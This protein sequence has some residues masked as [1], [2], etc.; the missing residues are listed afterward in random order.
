[1]SGQDYAGI[2]DPDTDFDSWYTRGTGAAIARR[3]S[4]GERVLELGCATGLMT[5]SFVAAGATVVGVDRSEQYL[6][7]ARARGL[8]GAT[9]VQGE[10]E[11][12]DEGAPFAHVTA[13]NL[14]HEVPD[15]D[16]F[17]RRCRERLE[18]GGYLHL[19]LQNPQSIHRLA[20]LELGMIGALHEVSARGQKYATL[21]LYDADQ[22]AAMGEAAGMTPVDQEGVMLKPLPND[23]M[24]LL[25]EQVLDGFQAVARHFPRH[26]AM[27]YLVFRR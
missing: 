9:F 1:M 17:L 26:C 12:Y 24:A 13:T 25:P 10:A 7:R 27:N 15:P 14:F 20:A 2:Y 22:L 4:P 5:V 21:Q 8:D 16:R 19:S 3:L 11:E 18:T 6:Q 23:W